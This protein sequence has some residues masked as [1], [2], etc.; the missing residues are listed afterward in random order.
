MTELEVVSNNTDK[1][2]LLFFKPFCNEDFTAILGPRCRRGG[3]VD[4]RDWHREP[5]RKVFIM[6]N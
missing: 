5:G 2:F 4:Y 6:G 3:W 1:I